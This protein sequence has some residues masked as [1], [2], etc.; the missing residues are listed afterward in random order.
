MR[1]TALF[2]LTFFLIAF[3]ALPGA[4]QETDIGGE[5]RLTIQSP[6]GPMTIEARFVQEGTE[7]TVTMTGPRGD[8][9]TGTGSIQGQAVRWSISRSTGSGERTVIYQGRVE[10]ATMSGTADLGERG[11]VDWAATKK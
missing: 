9:S 10:G 2:S 5:W 11:I 7:L 3:G 6:R 4:V 1:T 8:E